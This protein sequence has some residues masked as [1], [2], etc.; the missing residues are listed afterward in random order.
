VNHASGLLKAR[1]EHPTI[2]RSEASGDCV[3]SNRVLCLTTGLLWRETYHRVLGP[4]APGLRALTTPS[5]AH[6]PAAQAAAFSPAH[7]CAV[8]AILPGASRSTASEPNVAASQVD[9]TAPI[10]DGPNWQP[11]FRLDLSDGALRQHAL[12]K[13]ILRPTRPGLRSQSR[14]RSGLSASDRGSIRVW[15]RGPDLNRRHLDFQSS[16]LPS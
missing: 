15:C 5:S 12:P 2:N 10:E 3:I 9:A 1:T 14:F 16:A 7:G 4:V 8:P 13:P 11:R 6:T